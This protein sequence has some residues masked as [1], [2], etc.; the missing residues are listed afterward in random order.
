VLIPRQVLSQGTTYTV[1]LTVNGTVYT[2]SFNVAA[3]AL[4][5]MPEPVVAPERAME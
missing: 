5:I 2:W 1:S 3:G 4:S